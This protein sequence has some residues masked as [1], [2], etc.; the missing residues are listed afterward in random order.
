[1]VQ[2]AEESRD[3]DESWQEV[4]KV[5][6]EET[7]KTEAS[8]KPKKAHRGARGGA[9]DKKKKALKKALE[10][11]IPENEE[12]PVPQANVIV[13][14]DAVDQSSQSGPGLGNLELFSDRILGTGSGGTLV[15][16]GRWEDRDV[17]VKRMLVQHFELASSE[18]SN[19]EQTEGHPNVIKYYCRREDQHFLYIALEKCQGSIWDLYR[20]GP[21]DPTIDNRFAP[22]AQEMSAATRSVLRQLAEGLKYLHASRIVHRDIK[23]HNMLIAYPRKNE[24]QPRIVI[25]DFGLCKTLPDNVSTLIGTIVNAGT[26]GWKAP[27]LISHEVAASNTSNQ[28]SNGDTLNGLPA[29]AQGVKR[30]VDIFSLGCV[31]FYILTSG[32]HPYDD[33]DGW[34]DARQ[35]N[36]RHNRINLSAIALQDPD[37]IDLVKWMLAPMPEDR[38]TAAEVLS[39]PFFWNAEDRLNFLSVASDRFDGEDRDPP[40][41][42]LRALEAEA[43]GVIGKGPTTLSFSGGGFSTAHTRHASNGTNPLASL[44]SP[45]FLSKLDSKF[46]DTLGRQRKYKPYSLA[47][48]LRALRNKHHHWDDM[49]EDVKRVVGEVP[50][51]YLRYWERRFPGLVVA[52]WRVVR[53]AG[54]GSERRFW[55]WFGIGGG[56]DGSFG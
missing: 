12:E 9:R 10:A 31:F 7:E 30:A 8:P 11:E 26:A 40:S 38:P 32:R 4:E 46:L 13:K 50:E 39:H 5:D 42:T 53:E 1:M 22:L 20:N 37:T 15:F 34:S 27:E 2:N 16:E 25:S 52:V 44:G 19:L 17:A 36:I 3:V 29:S 33:D 35:R 14:P 6:S 28:S 43:E 23:P 48:L 47:D 21:G 55:R 24:I 56:R 54:I 49:P 45:D 51:G 18:I 41:T